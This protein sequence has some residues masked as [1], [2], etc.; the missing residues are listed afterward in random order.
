MTSLPSLT[1]TC[2][3]SMSS[4]KGENILGS[5]SLGLSL[6]LPLTS[7]SIGETER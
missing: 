5:T 6:G 7:V 4:M 1:G 2:L 3:L